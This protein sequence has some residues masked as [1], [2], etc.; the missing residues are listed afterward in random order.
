MAVGRALSKK[1]QNPKKWDERVS[2]KSKVSFAKDLPKI[3]FK[4]RNNSAV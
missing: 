3:V 4:R 2:E 1:I